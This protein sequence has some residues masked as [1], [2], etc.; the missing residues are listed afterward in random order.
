MKVQKDKTYRFKSEFKKEKYSHI[1]QAILYDKEGL[2]ITVS[3]GRITYY[4]A[5]V[6]VCRKVPGGDKVLLHT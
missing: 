1:N 4:H 2:P 5:I 3:R 6:K